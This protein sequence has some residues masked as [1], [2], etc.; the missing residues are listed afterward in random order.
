MELWKKFL[1]MKEIKKIKLIEEIINKSEVS[2]DYL[3]KKLSTTNKLIRGLLTELNIEQKQFYEDSIEYYNIENRMVRLPKKISEDTYT[4]FYL[5]LRKKYLNENPTFKILICFLTNRELT[6]Q[7]I[8][9][10]LNYSYSYCYKLISKV[11]N[12][13]KETGYDC[14]IYKNKYYLQIRGNENQIRLLS[15]MIITLANKGHENYNNYSYAN[16]SVSNTTKFE[17]ILKIFSSAIKKGYVLKENIDEELAIMDIIYKE[18]HLGFYKKFGYLNLKNS[19]VYETEKMFFYLF[20]TYY[21]PEHFSSDFGRKVYANLKDLKNTIVLK[22]TEILEWV[23]KKY[24]LPKE[25]HE[26]YLFHFI[27]IYILL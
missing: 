8:S 19:Q 21:L 27:Y 9:H 11:N 14:F 18:I 3:A 2:V 16:I 12:F 4:I 1:T 10:H 15:Y 23:E 20:I 24:N 13:F 17:N 26:F 22:S 25:F 6:M 7:Q 5:Y